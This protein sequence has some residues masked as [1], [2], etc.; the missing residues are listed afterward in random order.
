[1]KIESRSFAIKSFFIILQDR[2]KGKLCFGN[3]LPREEFMKH[4]EHINMIHMRAAAAL[5]L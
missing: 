5:V 3:L 1:M 4:E 2:K